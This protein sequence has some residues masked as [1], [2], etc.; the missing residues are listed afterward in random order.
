MVIRLHGEMGVRRE[1]IGWIDGPSV[2]ER[3]R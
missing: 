1:F 2:V 3:R